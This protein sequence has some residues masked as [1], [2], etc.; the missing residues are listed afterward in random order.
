MPYTPATV[1]YV[2]EC[3]WPWRDWMWCHMISDHSLDELHS[4][5]DLLQVPRRGFQGDHYD[6]PEH[7]R[8]RAVHHGAIQVPSREIVVR[9][10]E[11]GLRLTAEQ[12]SSFLA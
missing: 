12:R 6:L 10:R 7:V 4:F 5:A 2:D 8:E 1:I 3:R 9:L 11:S